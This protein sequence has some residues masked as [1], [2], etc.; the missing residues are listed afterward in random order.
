MFTYYFYNTLKGKINEYKIN[1]LGNNVHSNLLNGLAIWCPKGKKSHACIN[2][3]LNLYNENGNLKSKFHNEK[4]IHIVSFTFF[5][6]LKIKGY[7]YFTKI[8]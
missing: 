5:T 8:F 2:G 1:I 7:P 6:L 3:L 4:N